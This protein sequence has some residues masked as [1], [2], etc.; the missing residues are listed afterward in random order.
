VTVSVISKFRGTSFG[1]TVVERAAG[2]SPQGGTFRPR[3]P[4]TKKL[5]NPAEI[6]VQNTEVNV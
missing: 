2:Q 6:E 3:E 1:V 5:R 4:T